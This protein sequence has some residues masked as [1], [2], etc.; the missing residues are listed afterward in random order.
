MLAGGGLQQ[1]P[2]EGGV[3]IGGQQVVEDGGGV[4]LVDEVAL[5]RPFRFRRRD[6][7]GD[8]FAAHGQDDLVGDDLLDGRFEM[9]VYQVDPV[10]FVVLVLVDDA[11][12][13]AGRVRVLGPVGYALDGF[14]QAVAPETHGR[15]AFLADDYPDDFPAFGDDTVVQLQP[16]PE[17]VGVEGA[18]QAPVPRQHDDTH[19]FLLLMGLQQGELLAGVG[20]AGHLL[21]QLDHPL[22]VGPES[23][24][25]GLGAP[26][27]RAGH[28]LHG[29]GGLA[30]I[31]YGGDPP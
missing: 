7:I 4:W 1:R 23:L 12:G 25:A 17:D 27:A 6:H 29:L 2:V 21:H 10:Q 16:V 22:G 18:G 20:V 19:A 13:D 24:D 5:R 26:E 30:C 3:H 28:H 9:V 11:L 8:G 31:G 15:A 14:A